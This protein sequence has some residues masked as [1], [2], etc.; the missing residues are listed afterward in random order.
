MRATGLPARLRQTARAG[1][2]V[3]SDET[4]C[5]MIERLWPVGAYGAAG[6]SA[7][8]LYY[9]FFALECLE[10]LA[11]EGLS[12]RAAAL[13][14]ESAERVATDVVHTC[15][16]ARVLWRLRECADYRRQNRRMQWTL[17]AAQYRARREGGVYHAFLLAL[18]RQERGARVPPAGV[19]RRALAAYRRPDGSYVGDR[20]GAAGSTPVTAAAATALAL[21]GA[22]EESS[23][24]WLEAR[25]TEEGGFLAWPEA[26]RPDLLSTGVA[27]MA[28]R[29]GGRDL[30]ART[31]AT[32]EFVERCMGEFGLMCAM[33]GISP[34][35]DSEYTFYG[36]LA[37]GGLVT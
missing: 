25:Y 6:S 16:R 27:L 19:L 32:V 24:V 31:S 3:L 10:A 35:G 5:R 20:G 23:L 14:E 7:F 29:M 18:A 11:V 34:A 22:P 26:P 8:D 33:P 4:R 1:A 37:L 36:L 12:T 28:L 15:C 2:E 30:S 21:A 17:R 9:G 13:I